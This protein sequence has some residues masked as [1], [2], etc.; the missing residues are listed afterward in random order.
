MRQL[1]KTND[2]NE[3]KTEDLKMLS[4]QWE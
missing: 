1:S 3:M 2:V 4:V